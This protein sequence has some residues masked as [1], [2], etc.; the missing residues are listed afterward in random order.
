MLINFRGKVLRINNFRFSSSSSSAVRKRNTK[1]NDEIKL[2]TNDE[3]NFPVL[4]ILPFGNVRREQRILIK[5]EVCFH[6]Y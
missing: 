5:S 6:C 2:L 3:N 4:K 1:Q